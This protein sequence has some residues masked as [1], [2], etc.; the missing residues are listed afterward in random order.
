MYLEVRVALNA[1]Q[2]SLLHIAHRRVAWG[3]VQV[4]RRLVHA[5]SRAQVHAARRAHHRV[6]LAGMDVPTAIQVD[7]HSY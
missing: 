5:V 4:D 1:E 2:L 7:E 6:H 3:G